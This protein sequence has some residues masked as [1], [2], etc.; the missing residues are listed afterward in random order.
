MKISFIDT[1]K[2]AE[3]LFAQ[4]ART[5]ELPYDLNLKKIRTDWL[6]IRRRVKRG[7]VLRKRSQEL[8]RELDDF[9]TVVQGLSISFMLTKFIPTWHR[10]GTVR[11]DNFFARLFLALRAHEV[12]FDDV[13]LR[14][15]KK[16]VRD[17]RRIF[18]KWRV[19]ERDLARYSLADQVEDERRGRRLVRLLIFLVG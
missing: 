11:R 8:V 4:L 10:G 6:G 18:R 2:I 9:A 12:E 1:V 13:L 15:R 3:Q 16:R 7:Q 19:C 17:Y 14:I 5:G